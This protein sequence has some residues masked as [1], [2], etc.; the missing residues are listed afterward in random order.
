MPLVCYVYRHDH[1]QALCFSP[2][3]LRPPSFDSPPSLRGRR[4]SYKKLPRPHPSG[5]SAGTCSQTHPP[6]LHPILPPSILNNVALSVPTPRRRPS[7]CSFQSSS[8]SCQWHRRVVRESARAQLSI[9]WRLTHFGK[10][11]KKNVPSAPAVDPF[12][13]NRPS[14]SSP[15]TETSH[16]KPPSPSAPDTASRPRARSSSTP[17]HSSR[18][19][20]A[21]QRAKV[22]WNAR[23]KHSNASLL[24]SIKTTTTT[25]AT[26]TTATAALCLDPRESTSTRILF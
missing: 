15:S 20:S 23:R 4:H 24:P 21:K 22:A 13:A 11:H 16:R 6:Y 5:T 3:P 7:S 17:H 14:N 12:R 9:D 1:P 2:S 26:V 19:E 10:R 8:Q 18:L 25:T